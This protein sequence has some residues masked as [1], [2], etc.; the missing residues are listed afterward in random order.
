[1]PPLNNPNRSGICSMYPTTMLYLLVVGVFGIYYCC[2]NLLLECDRHKKYR[3]K[4]C[5]LV[6]ASCCTRWESRPIFLDK[7]NPVMLQHT[8][9]RIFSD[10]SSQIGNGFARQCCSGYRSS[11]WKISTAIPDNGCRD[12]WFGF[13]GIVMM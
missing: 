4:K 11:G 9:H 6:D 1:M 5:G 10:C 13:D 7:Y 8:L 3:R 12:P 2:Y